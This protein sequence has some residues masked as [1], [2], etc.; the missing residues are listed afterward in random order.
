MSDTF[1]RGGSPRRAALAVFAV[2][3]LFQLLWYSGR[4]YSWDDMIH[5]ETARALIERGDL[6]VPDSPGARAFARPG[7]DGRLYSK[8]GIGMVA[9]LAPF[10]AA[11][12]V[13]G[14]RAA[15]LAACLANPILIAATAAAFFLTALQLGAARG[16]ALAGALVLACATPLAPYGRALFNDPLVGLALLLA[17][18][19]WL[20]GEDA[21]ASAWLGIAVLTR[22]EYAVA[23]PA[24]FLAS[25]PRRWPRLAGPLA[26]ALLLL[27]AYNGAR[28]GSPLD[29]GQLAH[30]PHDTFS[31]PLATGLYGL[32][33]SPGKGLLWY[34][35][36]V[37]VALAGWSRRPGGA[38]VA[39]AAAAIVLPA[40]ILHAL[41]HSW[42][43][44]W[45]YGPRRLVALLPIL[46]LGFPFAWTR[47]KESAAG[48]AAL[49]V[50]IA[51]GFCAQLGGLVVDF[52]AYIAWAN[53]RGIST[54]WTA[55]GSAAVGHWR[56][57]A[58]AGSLDLWAVHLFGPTP[59]AAAAF[60]LA[61]L[62]FLAAL[63]GVRPRANPP[64]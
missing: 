4:L 32:L 26:A 54:L 25:P 17:F 38:R 16:S 56:Y 62:A 35:T 47:W 49:A 55:A 14:P 50:A 36:P 34:G 59:A 22:A 43:G 13:L 39:L 31:T 11:G 64:R 6:A 18:R 15:I 29:Q 23:A 19:S 7:V 60:T 40:I 33:L 41:W 28:F 58:E 8:F 45:S 44:G 63:N 42:M 5:L 21:L 20:R 48:K 52:M 3:L 30:D 37:L 27:L 53:G 2:T 24:L 46:M 51:A 12:S 61:A 9:W 1:R 57:L 10:Y